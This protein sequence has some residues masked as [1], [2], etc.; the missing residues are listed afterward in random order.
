MIISDYITKPNMQ[1]TYLS[2]DMSAFR[3]TTVASVACRDI[4]FDNASEVLLWPERK[5]EPRTFLL[6]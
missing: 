1:V 6:F 4:S 5:G 2:T 3:V